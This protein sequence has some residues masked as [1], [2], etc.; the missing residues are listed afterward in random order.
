MREAY[1]KV[2]A[3]ELLEAKIVEYSEEL[4]KLR[5]DYI[6]LDVEVG[7]LRFGLSVAT[8]QRDLLEWFISS[9]PGSSDIDYVGIQDAKDSD[10]ARESTD[11]REFDD[12]GDELEEIKNP[13]PKKGKQ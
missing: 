5:E 4:A 9:L 8:D 3:Q 10:E 2:T 12:F 6:V 13:A 1:E 7:T 11:V